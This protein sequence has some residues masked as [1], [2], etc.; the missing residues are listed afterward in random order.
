MLSSIHTALRRGEF[1][2]QR[3]L[4]KELSRASSDKA[5]NR[6]AHN[7]HRSNLI[8]TLRGSAPRLSRSSSTALEWKRNR[9][10]P[11]WKRA[12]GVQGRA[13]EKKKTLHAI[14]RHRPPPPP[15]AALSCAFLP[16]WAFLPGWLG[17]AVWLD[18]LFPTRQ[19]WL[20]A[21]P[22]GIFADSVLRASL[23]AG[24]RGRRALGGSGTASTHRS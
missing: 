11:A 14:A 10:F 22:A 2:R 13:R 3:L 4:V 17:G 9:Q 18:H 23:E 5:L 6:S 20:P 1:R 15:P 8:S 7:R 12:V 16:E 19:G 21:G 24:G